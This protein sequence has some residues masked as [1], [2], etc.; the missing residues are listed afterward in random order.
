M[1]VGLHTC[2]D[3]ASTTLRV[4]HSAE[5]AVGAVVSVGCCYMHLTEQDFE[6]NSSDG[7]RPCAPT[8]CTH[9]QDSGPHEAGFPMSTYVRD[10][11]IWA[12]FHAREA[13]CHSL[14]AYAERLQASAHQGEAGEASLR[15]HCWRAV[16]ELLISQQDSPESRV[17]VRNAKTLSFKEYVDAVYRR[18]GFPMIQPDDWAALHDELRPC[19]QRLSAVMASA[20]ERS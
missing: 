5:E 14:L 15:L 8:L 4:F 1:L 7:C 19:E 12:G 11:S 13:A 9:A 6:G 10:L 3:L 20:S 16:L 17:Q 18:I 2:G